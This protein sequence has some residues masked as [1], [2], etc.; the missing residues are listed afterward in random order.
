MSGAFETERLAFRRLREGMPDDACAEFVAAIREVVLQYNTSVEENRFTV[1]GVVEHLVCALLRA[2]DIDVDY[3]DE[4]G[5][6]LL[7][8]CGSGLS[9]KSQF[10]ERRQ[11]I[12]LLNTRNQ[13]QDPRW[14]YATLFVLRGTGIVYG[15]P[16]IQGV[17]EFVKRQSDQLQLRPGGLTLLSSEPSR[18]ISLPIP[19]KP[20]KSEEAKSL[21]FSRTLAR[22]VLSRSPVLGK[23]YMP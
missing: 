7:L 10:T 4:R 3:A 14:E 13:V 12:G 19:T 8:S 1:G 23:A 15:D 21:K 9:V 2:T 5:Y 20:P 11:P 16:L 6:D 18:V 22:E 17:D